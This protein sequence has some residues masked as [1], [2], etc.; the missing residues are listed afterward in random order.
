M[1]SISQKKPTISYPEELK[2][3]YKKALGLAIN[4]G[5]PTKESIKYLLFKAY[6][7]AKILEEKIGG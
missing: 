4:I 5:Y 3:A 7:E 6:N 1:K 2:L